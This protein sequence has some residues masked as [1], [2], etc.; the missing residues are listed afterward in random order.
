MENNEDIKVGD[1]VIADIDNFGYLYVTEL[2]ENAFG[3]KGLAFWVHASMPNAKYWSYEYELKLIT[4]A[5]R[6]EE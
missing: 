6:D 1:V 3:N 4:S 2:K 5:M